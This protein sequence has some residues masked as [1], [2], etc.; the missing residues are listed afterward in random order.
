V[1][2]PP[3]RERAEDIPTLVSHFLDK[4]NKQNGRKIASVDD[5]AWDRLRSYGWPGNV[6]E[7]ENAIE[8]AVVLSERTAE[9]MTVDLLPP[10]I[11]MAASA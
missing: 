6:R 2:I 5:S 11:R 3:L 4:Y 1:L 8:R 7:L 10:H 9:V